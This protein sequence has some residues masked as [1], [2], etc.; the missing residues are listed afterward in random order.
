[1]NQFINAHD[2]F[3]QRVILSSQRI[4]RSLKGARVSVLS[5][6]PFKLTQTPWSLL[7]GA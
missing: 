5:G 7:R 2:N 6:T 4:W 1:M 3:I